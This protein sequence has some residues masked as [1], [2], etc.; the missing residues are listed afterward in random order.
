MTTNAIERSFTVLECIKT[1]LRNNMTQQI[2][3]SLKFIPLMN[4][5]AVWYFLVKKE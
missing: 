2:L 5:N 4:V 1:Y 3:N